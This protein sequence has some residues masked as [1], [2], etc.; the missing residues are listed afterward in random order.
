MLLGRGEFVEHESRREDDEC[1]FYHSDA[2]QV[3]DC[4]SAVV[5]IQARDRLQV[6]V[7]TKRQSSN[8]KL[9]NS[10]HLRHLGTLKRP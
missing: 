2:I 6:K 9:V 1:D 8:P 5:S 10:S 3:L 4:S 7:A